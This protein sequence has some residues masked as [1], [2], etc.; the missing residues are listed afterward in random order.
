MAVCVQESTKD[1]FQCSPGAH[2]GGEGKVVDIPWTRLDGALVPLNCLHLPFLSLSQKHTHIFQTHSAYV[3]WSV[4]E[5]VVC[6][7]LLIGP[8][9]PGGWVTGDT[10]ETVCVFEVHRVFVANVMLQRN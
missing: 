3:C 5:E 4:V 10:G 8:Q 1:G 9:G 2:G 6:R 7:W